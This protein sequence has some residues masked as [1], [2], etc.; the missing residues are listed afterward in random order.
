MSKHKAILDLQLSEDPADTLVRIL[1]ADDHL[2]VGQILSQFLDARSEFETVTATD[3]EST[4][5]LLRGHDPFDLILLDLVMPGMDGFESVRRVVTE[6]GDSKV[7]IFSSNIDSYAATVALAAG[8]KG[9]IPKQM[10]VKSLI[11]A[12]QLVLSGEVFVPSFLMQSKMSG[13]D[14]YDLTE[15]ELFVLQSAASGLTNKHIAAEIGKNESA[16]KMHMRTIC[17]KLKARNRAHACMIGR[18]L[19]III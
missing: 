16:I 17:I 11:S 18:R 4:L 2:M 19:G 1:I 3:L 7:L 6:S 14:L 10:P 5:E 12:L 8:V 15:L 9:I 13:K